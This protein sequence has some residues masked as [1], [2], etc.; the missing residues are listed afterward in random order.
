MH[1]LVRLNLCNYTGLYI[2][3]IEFHDQLKMENS[4]SSLHDACYRG[5]LS[6]VQWIIQKFGYV[7]YER[8]HHGWT[9][10]HSAAYGG[11]LDVLH[12]LI[13]DNKCDPNASDDDDVTLLHMSSY[14]GHI[15]IVTYLIDVC[16]VL[17]D[18]VD[19][20]NTTA[21]MYA[22]LGG[23]DEVVNLLISKYQCDTSVCSRA[24]HS[25][26]LLACQ[27]GQKK[28]IHALE[29]LQLFN[30]DPQS[31]DY[32]GR[33]VI[34]YT[35]AGGSVELL[36]YL[37]QHYNLELTVQDNEGRTGLHI[38]AIYSSTEVAKYVMVKLR[39]QV[40]LDRDKHH[41]S[42]IYYA[43]HEDMPI[44]GSKAFRK[45][46]FV[47]TSNMCYHPK[48]P[49]STMWDY[50]TSS[51]NNWSPIKA[52]ERVSLVSWML[53]QC[54]T[55]A[56]FN[57]NAIYYNDSTL[58]HAAC[59]SGSISLMKVLEVYNINID[60]L[61]ND[62]ESALH[63][64][65]L[66]G[67][68]SLFKYLVNYHHLDPS[69][70]SYHG[71]I[72]LQYA[73]QSGNVN[74]VDYLAN[75]SDIN[76]QAPS[77]MTALH[78][79]SQC[80][81]YDIVHYLIEKQNINFY[82]CDNN[83]QNALHH[84]CYSGNMKLVQYLIAKVDTSVIDNDGRSILHYAALGITCSLSL[85]K[86]LVEKY[87]LSPHQVDQNGCL[88][89]H[90]AANLGHTAIVEYFIVDQ[91]MDTSNDGKSIL[92]HAALGGS[93][94]LVKL[95]VEKYQLSPHQV[96]QN[97]HLPLHYAAIQGHTTLVE[98][99]ISDQAMDTTV[100]SNNGKNILHYAALGGSLS[101][102]KLLVEKYQLSPHHI[103]QNG[104]LPL[105]YMLLIKATPL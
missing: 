86:I 45:L 90:Y 34:H 85:V 1:C 2:L 27:S 67:S 100:T 82:I 12:Y 16:N 25:L 99:F 74:I 36:E 94:S 46:T 7:K 87:Q 24:G 64:A 73:S 14:K 62:G 65:A 92:H 53:E 44:C 15:N 63:K 37:I 71:T 102:A 78:Y 55:L 20:Y 33:G 97:G 98:Y 70:K 95:L 69:G 52:S 48:T 49:I 58:V 88:P 103:D 40:A 54:S 105:Q 30:P 38:A 76:Y 84:A 8:G 29:S 47:L 41:C 83:N 19:C 26:S 89:L 79:S 18:A 39:P 59:S 68:L 28:A 104:R 13:D 51:I 56:D 93:L 43:C 31:V 21:V 32:V 50:S 23:Q 60:A 101:L 61:D 17:V 66:S 4:S 9:P 11:H 22:T 72:P 42:A 5:S 35:C 96:N 80:G 3:C 6:E 91:A 75:I 57:I 81:H 10:L 77:G